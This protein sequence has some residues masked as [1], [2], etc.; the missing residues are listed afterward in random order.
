[1][2]KLFTLL[3]GA[4]KKINPQE[5]I[6]LIV[7]IIAILFL[8][9]SIRSLL[10][11]GEGYYINEIVELKI[12]IGRKDIKID[13]L[14]INNEEWRHKYDSL[15]FNGVADKQETIEKLKLISIYLKKLDRK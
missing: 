4:L 3:A 5:R 1:M 10:S 7:F 8:T 12:D 11:K 15:Y 9:E 2:L 14:R 6:L 13:S